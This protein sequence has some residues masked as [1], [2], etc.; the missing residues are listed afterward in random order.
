MN[1]ENTTVTP[2]PAVQNIP[3]HYLYCFATDEACPRA[4]HCLHATAA[5][6]LGQSERTDPPALQS[7]SPVY[8]QKSAAQCSFFRD[9]TP[10]R[11]ARGMTH[12]FD[13]VPYKQLR[14]VRLQVMGCFSCERYFYYSQE[15]KR[16]ITPQE[17]KAIQNVFRR[18][19]IS[20]VPD[21]D[22]YS[23]GVNW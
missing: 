9:S 13:L 2:T 16:L 5:R 4:S 17:Q 22:E 12:L 10:V 6:L 8:I 3:Y 21:F 15:G 14:Q 23:E 11:F 1:H 20:P 19:G 7:V 18:A